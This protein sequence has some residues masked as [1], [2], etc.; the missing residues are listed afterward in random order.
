[1][2]WTDYRAAEA[3]QGT[4]PHTFNA[5]QKLV[6]AMAKYQSSRGKTT[7][8]GRD[9]G[10][11][12]Y[13]LFE[14]NLLDSLLAMVLDG[15]IKRNTSPTECRN[16]LLE[17]LKAFEAIFPNWQ[18]AYSFAQEYLVRDATVAEDRI[19]DLFGGALSPQPHVAR[20]HFTGPDGDHVT[21]MTVGV[22]IP[23]DVYKR[24]A[25]PTTGDLYGLAYYE[26][27]VPKKQIVPKNI[28][29]RARAAHE[30]IDSVGAEAM[31]RTLEKLKKL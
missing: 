17:A 26:N 19:R 5:L 25:D 4:Y 16:Q 21:E 22:E 23:V 2:A 3:F 29:E 9:K 20:V 27:G 11:A 14:S 10:L 31:Q 24:A 18:D 7:W 12:A 8:F 1:M 6:V 28:W 15:I 30:E 13:K